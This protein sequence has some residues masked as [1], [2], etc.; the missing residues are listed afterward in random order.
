VVGYIGG[1]LSEAL[2]V[3]LTPRLGAYQSA[4]FQAFA[5]MVGT[6]ADPPTFAFNHDLGLGRGWSRDAARLELGL[7]MESA[8]ERIDD[9]DVLPA[10]QGQYGR[11]VTGWRHQLGPNWI[12]DLSGGAFHARSSADEPSVTGPAWRGTVRWRGRQFRAA[13]VYDHNARPSVVLGG[14]FLAD[15]VTLRT[16][17][18][19]GHDERFRVMGALRYQQLRVLDTVE[20]QAGPV[21]RLQ[22]QLVLMGRPWPRRHVELAL[23]YRFTHQDEGRLAR[24]HLHEVRRN[25]LLL[26]LT[27]GLPLLDAE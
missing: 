9:Q 13:A 24:R 1:A 15:R 7:G 8:P 18:R 10:Q 11:L 20:A 12:T 5:P 27:V 16:V 22:A 21:G 4:D 2:G 6:H 25:V 26:T 17:G 14:V 23:S 19:F 3:D